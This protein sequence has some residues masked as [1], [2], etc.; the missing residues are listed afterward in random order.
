MMANLLRTVLFSVLLTALLWGLCWVCQI[1]LPPYAMLF[2][3]FGSWL[4]SS[5]AVHNHSQ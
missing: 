1:V 3:C 2:I 4:F 5:W